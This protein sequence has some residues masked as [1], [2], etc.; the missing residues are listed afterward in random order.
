MAGKV[1]GRTRS[2]TTCGGSALMQGN[3]TGAM[4]RR[5]LLTRIG[6]TAGGA[7]MYQAM[8][9]LGMAA[10]SNFKG[11][12]QLDGDPKGASVLILG[13]GLAGMSAAFELRKAGYR[14]QLLEYND[15][16]GGRNWTLR[17]GD[18]YTELGGATQHCRFDEG[19]YLNPGPW[20]IPH[21]HKAVLSYCKQFGVALEAFNQVNYNALLHSQTGFGSKP[22]RFR[23]IDADYKGHVSELLAKCTQQHALDAAVS[24]ED[25]E[26]LLE[27]LR[28]WGGARPEVRLRQGQEQQ[29][30]TRFC[31]LPRWWFVGQAGILRSFQRAGRA[32]LAP[33]DDVGSRQQL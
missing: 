10:E 5:Q 18:R 13:A 6:M 29:R 24:R 4:T 7:M 25:Q 31:A 28:T 19:L 30:A 32:A 14:V 3:H 22:Q 8:S 11:P 26:L 1:A 23:A 33:V 21:H 2:S 27:S 15:R 16:P 9:S 20:R 12:L 17:G